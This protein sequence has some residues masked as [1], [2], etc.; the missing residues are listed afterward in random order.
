MRRSMKQR[1]INNVKRAQN[2]KVH[3]IH[4][5][6]SENKLSIEILAPN[7]LSKKRLRNL[8]VKHLGRM[9]WSL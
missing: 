3:H 5:E 9:I 7:S 2:G 1:K 4:N 8:L 6:M